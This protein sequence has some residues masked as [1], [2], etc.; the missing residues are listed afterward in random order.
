MFFYYP[1]SLRLRSGQA[2]HSLS[3]GEKEESEAEK[4]AERTEISEEK[5]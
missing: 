4:R 2:R 5:F 1:S 3:V